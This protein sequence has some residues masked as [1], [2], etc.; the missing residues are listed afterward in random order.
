[1]AEDPVDLRFLGEQIKRLQGDVR[2]LKT[3]GAQMRADLSQA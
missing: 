1:M 3:D 2:V